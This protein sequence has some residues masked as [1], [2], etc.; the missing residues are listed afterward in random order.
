MQVTATALAKT[1]N[2]LLADWNNRDQLMAQHADDLSK[3]IIDQ[4][5]WEKYAPET[6]PPWIFDLVVHELASDKCVQTSIRIPGLGNA[7]Q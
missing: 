1:D 3:T 7:M 6:S 4:Y 2:H 5:G